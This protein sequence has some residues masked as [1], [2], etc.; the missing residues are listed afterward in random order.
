MLTPSKRR[1]TELGTSEVNVAALLL[2]LK[3]DLL[4]LLLGQG[5][6][7]PAQVFG[8]Q[9]FGHRSHRGV[10]RVIRVGRLLTIFMV[11]RVTMM[12]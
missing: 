12:T 2:D 5:A 11:S 9:G 6:W 4:D 7:K 10:E 8:Q 3:G 1:A